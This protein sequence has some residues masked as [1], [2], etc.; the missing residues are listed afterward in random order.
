MVTIAARTRAAQFTRYDST[1]SPPTLPKGNAEPSSAERTVGTSISQ[2]VFCEWKRTSMGKK[3]SG[4]STAAVNSMDPLPLAL[5][6]TGMTH[7]SSDSRL[8][9]LAPSP[10]VM[11]GASAAGTGMVMCTSRSSMRLCCSSYSTLTVNPPDS[12]VGQQLISNG[13]WPSSVV[14]KRHLS[15]P[16]AEPVG[17]ALEGSL[18]PRV[19]SAVKSCLLML[20]CCLNWKP[21]FSPIRS[22]T[23][24][25]PMAASVIRSVR[26]PLTSIC[27]RP[28]SRFIWTTTFSSTVSWMASLITRLAGA[29]P[30]VAAAVGLP[31]MCG[32]SSTS[33]VSTSC[34][35][36]EAPAGPFFLPSAM[37]TPLAS[38]FW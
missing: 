10:S 16:S 34:C 31:G 19:D 33:P 13:T 5:S 20:G 15:T 12:C 18:R 7:V 30:P 9:K 4:E 29:E 23:V 1:E 35:S 27:S 36:N 22:G 21:G 8:L 11:T 17:K 3:A 6:M 2:N 26:S 28:P 24:T 38:G 25:F 37:P 32:A 14:A